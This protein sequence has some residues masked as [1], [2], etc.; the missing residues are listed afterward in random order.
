MNDCHVRLSST[1]TPTQHNTTEQH[2]TQEPERGRDR[3][4]EERKASRR[5]IV[6]EKE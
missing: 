5:T 6:L 4:R 3:D 1:P 2:T